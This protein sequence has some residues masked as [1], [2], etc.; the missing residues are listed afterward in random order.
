MYANL[1]LVVEYNKQSYR[2]ATPRTVLQFFKATQRWVRKHCGLFGIAQTGASVQCGSCSALQESS[3]LELQ[4]KDSLDDHL[5]SL[6]KKLAEKVRE[7]RFSAS[8]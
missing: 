2:R 4:P 3:G 7:V 5:D 6:T 8:F 1:K